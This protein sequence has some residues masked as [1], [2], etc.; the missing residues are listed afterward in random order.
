MGSWSVSL[1]T[2][3]DQIEAFLRRDPI[4]AAYAI[5]D[6][7]PEHAPFCTW[8][9][10]EV[11]G[12]IR[13][14]A[15][16]YRRID[17]PVLLTI[18]EAAGIEAIFDTAALPDRCMMVAQAEHLPV[19]QAHY[20]FNGDQIY[21]MVRMKLAPEAFRPAGSQ[22]VNATLV[23]LNPADVPAIEALYAAGGPFAPD[24]FSP[25]QVTEGVFFGLEIP[26]L[27]QMK[28]HTLIAVAGTHLVA[29]TMGVAAVGNIYTHPA[30]RGKGYG[31]LVT[32]AVTE[33]LLNR[34]LLVVLN[35]DEA[36]PAAVHLY[37]KLGY[38]VHCLFV[39]G[40]GRRTDD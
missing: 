19:F 15:L 29:P 32:S 7:E 1:T 2:D 22:P 8:R 36:N 34:N 38:R 18:G 20:D 31:Q 9:L 27:D 35:V 5:G 21:H 30:Q 3:K 24:A 14:L 26:A 40:G 25:A 28:R 11:D 17:P 13:A 23:R 12:H 16:E 39:E 6:L 33:E 4:Y 37:E 10:A